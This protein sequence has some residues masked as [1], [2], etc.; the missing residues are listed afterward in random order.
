MDRGWYVEPSVFADVGNGD[1]LAR[2]EILG[3]ILSIMA[4]TDKD[5]PSRWPTIATSASLER[6]GPAT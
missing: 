6:F 3:P 4:Y 5:E 1:L 2:E